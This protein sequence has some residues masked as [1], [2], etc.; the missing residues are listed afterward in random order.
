MTTVSVAEFTA[1]APELLAIVEAGD[2][3]VVQR[4]DK[5]IARLEP[6]TAKTSIEAAP[7]AAPL[8]VVPGRKWSEVRGSVEHP[9]FGEDAQAWVS[10]TRAESD[11]HRE[12]ESNK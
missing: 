1:R 7:V 3:V 8:R 5:P 9:L 10:R 4:N 12:L 6:S 11:D 2:T